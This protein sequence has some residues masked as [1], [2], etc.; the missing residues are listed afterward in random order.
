MLNGLVTKG[1]LSIVFAGS[2]TLGLPAI[3]ADSSDSQV[4]I[5]W[6]APGY[7]INQIY[8]DESTDAGITWKVVQQLPPDAL[9]A[10]I[11]GLTNQQNY[12]FRIQFL[13]PDGTTSTPSNA[14][15][16]VPTG[17]PATPT[18]L[19]ATASI[20]QVSLQWATP[21][22]GE[23]IIGYEVDQSSD[24]GATWSVVTANT[25]SPAT[26]YLISGLTSGTTYTFQVKAIAFGG[27]SS[28]Y[29][30][31]ASVLVGQLV[32]T[33]YPLSSTI[34]PTGVNLTWG[35]PTI[36][37][38]LDTYRI[39][40]ST[41]GGLTWVLA[42]SVDGAINKATV[43][44][45]L[46]GALYRVIATAIN[47][48]SAMSQI[49]LAQITDDPNAQV[50]PNA[51]PPTSSTPSG[52]AF[53]HYQGTITGTLGGITT[54]VN[55]GVGSRQSLPPFDIKIS[56]K[57][58]AHT[59]V[60][61]L[62]LLS[63]LTGATTIAAR[64]REDEQTAL[65]HV[66]Y[67][68]LE[69]LD[70]MEERGDLSSTWRWPS[71]DFAQKSDAFVYRTALSVNSSS[72]LLARL[73]LDG[74]YLRAIFGAPALILW[75]LGFGF[76]VLSLI[77]THAQ[78]LP[79]LGYVTLGLITLGILDAASSII[80]LAVI[81]ATTL[82]TGGYGNIPAL[83]TTLGLAVLWFGPSLIASAARPLR[84][85]RPVTFEIEKWR[86]ERIGD[87]LLGPLLSAW[88]VRTMIN[89]LPALSGLHLP[90]ANYAN[91]FAIIAGVVVAI[92]YGLEELVS[93]FYP[94]RLRMVQED[95]LLDTT[96]D[97][98]YFSLFMRTVLFIIVALPF[99]GS[100]WQLYAGAAMFVAP[101][102]ARFFSSRF[103]NFPKLY[104]ILPAGLP[105]IAVMLVIG[106]LY[107]S[108]VSHLYNGA[109]ATKMGFVLMS[110]PGLAFSAL[111]LIGRAPADGDLRWYMRDK[112]TWLYRIGA[113]VVITAT[114]YL[115]LR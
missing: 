55:G 102:I 87:F 67:E 12:W 70:G 33:A 111:S 34:T 93:R 99:M 109:S 89:G 38:T 97:Q 78:A 84:R 77:Q 94:A 48:Q 8:L 79:P 27:I 63:I 50:D 86:W 54:S 113:V 40:L 35:N 60:A 24:G 47:G 43:P 75:V 37:A 65:E 2:A 51:T 108:W 23:S 61:A 16:A 91:F 52:V 76:G 29:S 66:D 3:S 25:H 1:L 28:E 39:E 31:P 104:Q 22:A 57:A 82:L 96:Q 81:F 64:R 26:S 44:Y 68:N 56:P 62:A 101:A 80:A 19:S 114:I 83:R 6:Q 59:Q 30:A 72:P 112:N 53:P 10:F 9:H 71:V 13:L 32:D 85:P 107:S 11:G 95:D 46:G 105:K 18:D 20:D 73:T 74:S 58:V 103:P 69:R 17:A 7:S 49:T 106:A 100:C 110:I 90:L 115:A 41:D 4:Q 88:A 21:T 45:V 14:V 36:T 42:T 15:V 92:R 5:S 98:K